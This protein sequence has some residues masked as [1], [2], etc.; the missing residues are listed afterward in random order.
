MNASEVYNY[1][2]AL[3]EHPLESLWIYGGEP[4]LYPRVLTEIVKIA[5]IREIQEIGVLTNGYWAKREKSAFKRL[6]VLKEAGVTAMTISTDGFHAA[7][8]TPELAIRAGQLALDAGIEKVDYSVTF[9][10]PRSS[11]NLY[12]DLSEEI[13]DRLKRLDGVLVRE[14]M[15]TTV[16]RAAERLVEHDRL[17]KLC[18]ENPCLKSPRSEKS[19]KKNVCRP[20]DYIGGSW[21]QL[22]GL[23]IDPDGWIMIC[24]GLSLGRVGDQPLSKLLQRY[25]DDG[26]ILWQNV[27][28]KGAHGLLDLAVDRGYQARS[29][30]AD[31]CHLCYDVRKYLQPYFQSFISPKDCYG[32]PSNS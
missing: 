9:L 23:E 4:F 30:Y 17:K 25:E 28:R 8:V 31:T 15:V 7:A 11:S 27:R 20:P 5:R 16:G 10:P 22:Q 1:L 2:Q 21:T 14:K 19:R 3:K 13:W 29:G 12:N 6:Q 32:E 26:N 24:P 18:L